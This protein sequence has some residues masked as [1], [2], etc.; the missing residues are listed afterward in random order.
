MKILYVTQWFE[1]EP[2]FKG[3]RFAKALTREGDD[4]DVVTAFPNY[5]GGKIYDGYRIKPV[6]RETFDGIKV[7]RLPIYPSHDN[8]T[9]GRA[10]NYISFFCSVLIYGLFRG[11]R[12]DAVYVYHPPITPAAAAAIFSWIYRIPLIVEIQD[13]WPDSVVASRMGGG[14]FHR[15][16]TLICNFVYRR[17]A[18]IICQSNGMIDRLRQ[19]GVAGEKISRQ[20]NWST[21]QPV[22]QDEIVVPERVIESFAGKLNMVYGGNF[23]EAQNLT[24]VIDAVLAAAEHVPN[25]RLHLVGSGIE[26]NKLSAHI[27][28]SNG[29]KIAFIYEPV[30]RATM[31]RIFDKADILV[32]HLRNDPLFEITLPSKLQHYLSCGK[33]IIAGLSG[34]AASIVIKSK[35]GLVSC[36]NDSVMMMKAICDIASKTTG[37]RKQMGELG[38]YYYDK[39]MSFDEGISLTIHKIHHA[40][41]NAK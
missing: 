31:D 27:A 12:Y 23:G 15:V 40:D 36:P 19:R 17:A 5:P 4:V 8:N 13:L 16:L 14:K 39:N 24:I 38:K 34:E 7:T 29:S 11:Y 22:G 10:F 30:D 33:P 35:A 37:Q 3:K 1:P 32:M 28:Q 20:Y 26:Q 18:H 2:A 25:L 9:L 41:S 21:Y 6:H